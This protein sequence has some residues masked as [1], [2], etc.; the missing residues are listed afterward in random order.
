MRREINCWLGIDCKARLRRWKEVVAASRHRQAAA[1]ACQHACD[2]WRFER[3]AKSAQQR[4]E[5]ALAEAEAGAYCRRHRRRAAL[6]RWRELLRPL[7]L[8]NLALRCH[9]QLWVHRWHV[10][11]SARARARFD[12]DRSFVLGGRVHLRRWRACAR[13]SAQRGAFSLAAA[14]TAAAHDADR[15]V[16]PRFE[17]W[18]DS[19]SDRALSADAVALA[20][21]RVAASLQASRA[22]RALSVWRLHAGR[23][24]AYEELS[25]A[26]TL[27]AHRG[28]LKL[29][30]RALSVWAAHCHGPRSTCASLHRGAA[31]V[32]AARRL[33]QR[34]ID[35]WGAHCRGP[36]SSAALAR[37]RAALDVP[38][39]RAL[40]AWTTFRRGY[41]SCAAVRRRR[42]AS[43]W[44]KGQLPRRAMRAFLWAYH[45][46]ASDRSRVARAADHM[47]AA[48]LQA[49]VVRWRTWYRI[50]HSTYRISVL[51]LS[52]AARRR[53]IGALRRAVDAAADAA[54]ASAAARA[55]FLVAS[56]R[57]A[58][59]RWGQLV[60]ERA[61]VVETIN[62]ARRQAR[63]RRLLRS[64]LRLALAT[65]DRAT[66]RE[67]AGNLVAAAARFGHHRQLGLAMEVWVGTTGLWSVE[68][69]CFR[70]LCPGG[71]ICRPYSHAS[72]RF[73]RF[74]ALCM[75]RRARR[76]W[77]AAT[78]AWT[79][80]RAAFAVA[81]RAHAREVVSRWRLAALRV[82][83]TLA[84]RAA[85]LEPRR[86]AAL[87]AW[88]QRCNGLAARRAIESV[89]AAALRKRMLCRLR[90]ACIAAPL[91]ALWRS[92]TLAAR[93]SARFTLRRLRR[94]AATF[95]LRAARSRLAWRLA[96]WRAMRSLRRGAAL[97]GEDRRR[98]PLVRRALLRSALKW[99][100][101]RARLAWAHAV[102]RALRL[103]WAMGLLSYRTR[104]RDRLVRTAGRHEAVGVAHWR[105]RS[106]LCALI[107]LGRH[108]AYLRRRR[109]STNAAAFVAVVAG[110][111][112][113][114][115]MRRGLKALR[116]SRFLA[117]LR[118]LQGEA[119][120]EHAG[121]VTLRRAVLAF[122]RRPRAHRLR[123][124][125][126]LRRGWSGWRWAARC[127]ASS[128]ELR[129]FGIAMWD[130]LRAQRAVRSWWRAA[131]LTSLLRK[132][133]ASL[134]HALESEHSPGSPPQCVLSRHQERS[135][136][137]QP[138][139]GTFRECSTMQ[140]VAL[141]GPWRGGY[142]TVSQ[143]SR[144]GRP[145]SHE[146]TLERRC[147][148]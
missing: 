69:A 107:A 46:G 34:A 143:R 86:A 31:L 23:V 6:G 104:L 12:S 99:L 105:V 97:D 100:R 5:Y 119:A 61:A 42:G 102:C 38:L 139:L 37:R 130:Q 132:Q 40:E 16:R 63:S 20:A 51:Q 148:S 112:C 144:R 52:V 26:A 106:A 101:S 7:M 48:A 4:R 74:V 79:A 57:H 138:T 27:R 85:A 87:A 71:G 1:L 10:R 67:L 137:S 145:T 39:R 11:V 13:A 90:R 80:R 54:A 117:Q 30:E 45:R 22:A 134:R 33:L 19:S 121:A 103:R 25:N 73:D 29:V 108:R 94:A 36:L 129:A 49:L 98:G 72:S 14:A 18:A 75:L 62:C 110:A 125:A 15:R 70:S 55:A 59:R 76:R 88:R 50:R 122:A 24:A 64:L 17:R 141:A 111:A 136:P 116:G 66:R 91:P 78:S 21:Q 133:H 53:G 43:A 83:Q 47:V 8:V 58:L 131:T 65:R 120:R 146:G 147:R 135:G 68:L 142:R 84:A 92:P 115:R 28:A 127:A 114:C 32:W 9:V 81:V 95:R 56:R 44:S 128:A 96:L 140:D 124:L 2:R 60:S 113:R 109:G 41:H 35:A 93:A 123:R 89:A 118:A 82:G 77:R 3:W 126:W